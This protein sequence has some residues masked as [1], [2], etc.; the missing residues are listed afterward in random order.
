MHGY[1][2]PINCTRTR[3][4]LTDEPL[5]S[6][7]LVQRIRVGICQVRGDWWATLRRTHEIIRRKNA[8]RATQRSENG[9]ATLRAVEDG[10]V[11]GACDGGASAIYAC[12]RDLKQAPGDS[13]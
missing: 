10:C 5:A 13:A 7:S 8:E 11:L 6:P 12:H 2:W 9:G 4:C 1:K 3:M